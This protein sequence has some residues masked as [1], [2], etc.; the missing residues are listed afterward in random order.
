MPQ[1]LRHRRRRVLADLGRGRRGARPRSTAPA[2][3]RPPPTPAALARRRP[4][5]AAPPR[6]AGDHGPRRRPLVGRRP[7]PPRPAVAGGGPRARRS[8][9]RADG[10]PAWD[11]F[12]DAVE[13]TAPAGRRGAR[14]RIRASSRVYRPH[15]RPWRP[16]E[17]VRLPALAAT[18]ERARRRRLRRLLRGRDRR[19][20][21]A[22]AGGRRL[23]DH[24]RP[25]SR[26]HTST[27]TRADRDRL[28]RRPGHDPPAE[29]LGH[30]RARAAEH[31]RARSS[32]RRRRRSGRT[33]SPTRAWIHLGIEAAKL[34]MAD[35]D[36][37]LTDPEFARGPGRRD[38]SI[39][40]HA[41][42]LAAC[43]DPRSG[44]RCR[45]PSPRT[46]RGGGTVYLATVDGEGNA[47]SLI[48]SNYMGFGS[49]V[50]DPG[51]RDPLPEPRLVLQ[52]RPGPP[53]RAR[54]GQAD[55]PH[56]A[57]RDAVPG[58]RAAARGSSP[59]RWA[60]TPSRRSTP[61]SCRRSSMAAL[62]VAT[63]VAAPRWFVEPA[64]RTSRRRRDVRAEP[65]LAP[66]VARGAR[67]AG[68]PA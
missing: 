63:A 56:A 46:R 16:G 29:Q 17:R 44:A 18:L 36:C 43:I 66:G 50:V 25:T 67:G 68:P 42:A 4:R 58:R 19:A 7:R 1:R 38:C 30:R 15:G 31:P 28:S 37:H 3:R 39:T 52:P 27:W 47:V 64:R 23:A 54:A 40:A 8:S 48:E 49:G 2:A 51:D 60:A 9:S 10:F 34:A 26:R 33:A 55:A 22:R 59:A 20:A 12:I 32:R 53:E 11:G 57:P 5:D 6:A 62:D 65:R 41:A 24:G 13:R 45:R 35:R 61:S 14:P 21:G